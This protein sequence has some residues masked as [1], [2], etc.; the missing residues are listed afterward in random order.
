MIGNCKHTGL[1]ACAFGLAVGVTSAISMF[2]F[3]LLGY[4]FNLGPPLIE[5]LGS[6]YMG[7]D[8]SVKGSF[9]GAFWG[10]IDGFIG[11]FIIA[12]LYNFFSRCCT[13]RCASKEYDVPVS[14]DDTAP[15]I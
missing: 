2:I 15:K 6:L 5:L 14:K 7:F 4:F 12:W 10:F 1:H 11:G 13:K 8:A 3:G 9:L